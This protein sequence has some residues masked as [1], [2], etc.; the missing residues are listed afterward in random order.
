MPIKRDLTK[1]KN[2]SNNLPIYAAILIV[3]LVVIGAGYYLLSVSPGHS[4]AP[5]NTLTVTPNSTSGNTSNSTATTVAQNSS[6]SYSYYL[7]ESQAA[8]IAGAGGRYG[9]ETLNQ[10]AIKAQNLPSYYNVSGEYLVTYV[11]PPQ[12]S[13]GLEE[14][15]YKT[16][17]P[18][19]VYQYGLQLSS[20]NF[21]SS[22]LEDQGY[23]GINTKTNVT[24]GQ[25]EYSYSSYFYNR[26]GSVPISFVLFISMKNDAVAFVKVQTN[27]TAVNVPEL[28]NE[29]LSQLP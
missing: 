10:S 16:A 24:T 8:A 5:S 18:Q 6:A 11:L 20:R 12:N 26:S 9:S 25:S 15:V 4:G 14:L 19:L 28:A 1:T 22:F 17:S 7:D 2:K 21:N 13:N 23:S 3:V 27:S 29:T